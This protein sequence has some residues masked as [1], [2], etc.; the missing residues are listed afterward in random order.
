MHIQKLVDRQENNI[1]KGCF[2]KFSC[3]DRCKHWVGKQGAGTNRV[4]TGPG[5][6]QNRVVTGLDRIAWAWERRSRITGYGRTGQADAYVYRG[7]YTVKNQNR[8]KELFK[9]NCW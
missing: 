1:T 6:E 3:E 2:R 9:I 8:N 5:P 7:H 4:G